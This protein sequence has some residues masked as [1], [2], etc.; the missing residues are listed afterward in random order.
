MCKFFRENYYEIYAR[1]FFLAPSQLKSSQLLLRQITVALRLDVFSVL[2]FSSGFRIKVVARECPTAQPA[3]EKKTC[4]LFFLCGIP[5]TIIPC[6]DSNMS[7]CVRKTTIWVPTRSDTNRPVQ[8]QK[9]ARSLKPQIHKKKGLYYP[10]S[11]NKGFSENN[12]NCW[13]SHAQA[14]MIIISHLYNLLEN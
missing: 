6:N 5:S 12:E 3:Y 1:L 14:L 10:S 2:L 4:Q 7:L 8:S 9:Q 13:F 11:E